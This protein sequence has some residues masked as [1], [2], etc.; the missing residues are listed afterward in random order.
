[1]ALRC[2]VGLG[3]PLTVAVATGGGG[4]ALAARFFGAFLLGLCG[5][6]SDFVGEPGR[7]SPLS[8]ASAEKP[9]ALVRLPRGDSTGFFLGAIGR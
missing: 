3:R 2:G 8:S 9:A 4:G 1:M 7:P 6:G 5:T